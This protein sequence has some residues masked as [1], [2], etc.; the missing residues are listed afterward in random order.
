[1]NEFNLEQSIGEWRQQ[2]RDGGIRSAGV[3]DELENHL[4]EAVDQHESS[5]LSSPLAFEKA[6]RQIGTAALLKPEFG[7]FG[8]T[9]SLAEHAKHFILTLAGIRN[10]TLAM[11]MNTS[12]SKPNLEPGWTT[13]LKSTAFVLPA[14][15]LWIFSVVFLFPKLNQICQSTGVAIPGVYGFVLFLSQ[16]SLLLAAVVGLALG[17]LEW[18]SEKW[19]R[20]RRAVVGVGVFAVNSA[21]ILL[22][23][24]MV[25]LALI[26]ASHLLAGK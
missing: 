13:Y 16:Y 7:K 25:L 5:G 17:L 3:L 10:P 6:A 2:M 4:R 21:A 12:H 26:S 20:Y 24:G 11:A 22:I 14:A 1:M 19:P 15:G 8:P 23:T 9:H 18:R